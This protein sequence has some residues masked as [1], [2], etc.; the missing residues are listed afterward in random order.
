MK[1]YIVILIIFSLS[2]SSLYSQLNVVSVSDTLLQIKKNTISYYLP[3]KTFEIA[4]E[5]E[6]THFIS[7]PYY[8]Y[9]EK[10]LSIENVKS[11][12]SISSDISGIQIA[13]NV[14]PDPEAGFLVFNCEHPIQFDA[15]GFLVAYNTSVDVVSDNTQDLVYNPIKY[16]KN[17]IYYTDYSVKRNFI[18][19]TDTTYKV[20]KLDSVFQK[21]P[22]YNTIIT[23]KDFEQ[24][25]EEAANFI[26]KIRKRR[27][28]LLSGQYETENFPK[29]IDHLI[30]ELNDLEKQYLELFIGKEIVFENSYIY[31]FTPTSDVK[32][33]V[34]TM[35]YISDELGVVE[36]AHSDALPVKLVFENLDS[37]NELNN[38]YNR[39]NELEEKE[40]KKGLYYRMPGNAVISVDFDSHTYA[41][42]NVEVPQIGVLNHLPAKMFRNRKLQI[43]FD[44]KSGSIK[45]I[46]NE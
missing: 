14:S 41:F 44:H 30:D 29:N 28:K 36:N 16:S 26:I 34:E 37:H 1:K 38:F 42:K 32:Q 2:L 43:I 24:K 35:F 11:E 3:Q 19:L 12:N 31:S 8:Q 7:G 18:G 20:V 22:V 5:V 4:V 13:E 40:K 10:Y 21:I 33:V 27:F 17:E 46:I 23:S 9:A 6:T 25:A 45:S 39:Q 15:S